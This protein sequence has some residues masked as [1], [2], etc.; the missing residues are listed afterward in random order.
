MDIIE[1]LPI[2]LD[3]I[4]LLGGAG[5]VVATFYRF[6]LLPSRRHFNRVNAGMDTLLG[7]PAVKDPGSGREIQPA[8]PPLAARVYDLEAT[9]AKMADALEVIAHNQKTILAM[10]QQFEERRIRGEQIVKEFTA[11]RETVERRL[12]R[13]VGEQDEIGKIIREQIETDKG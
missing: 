1:G 6:V 3:L 11:W 4:I 5:T 13:W 9:N 2:Y 8:T 10:E 12:E 7:Y